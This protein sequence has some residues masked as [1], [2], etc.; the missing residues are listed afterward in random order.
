M[1]KLF[2]ETPD[3]PLGVANRGVKIIEKHLRM[4]RVDRAKDLPE[5]ARVRLFRDL[6]AF[7]ESEMGEGGKAGAAGRDRGFWAR[8]WE[9]IENFLSFSET[10]ALMPIA[11]CTAGGL[12]CIESLRAR[13][14]RNVPQDRR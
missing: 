12:A 7:F 1:K 2:P 6:Q 10:D 13:L 4:H 9:R 14:P 8:L 11:V 3:V 5:E